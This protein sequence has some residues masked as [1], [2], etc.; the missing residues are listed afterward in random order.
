MDNLHIRLSKRNQTQKLYFF[1][2]EVQEPATLIHG[3][4][5]Q[6]SGARKILTK[7]STRGLSVV[8]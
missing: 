7:K 5:S 2:H 4:V 6:N 3:D 1:L 8:M